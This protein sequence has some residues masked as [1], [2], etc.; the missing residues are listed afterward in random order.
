MFFWFS[1]QK[2][3]VHCGF[4]TDGELSILFI[5]LSF[6][7]CQICLQIIFRL[8]GVTGKPFLIAQKK[9]QIRRFIP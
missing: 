3:T 7:R 9:G 5:F 4:F 8:T 1:P 6:L 2:R